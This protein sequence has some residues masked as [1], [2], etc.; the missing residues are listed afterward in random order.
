VQAIGRGLELATG[1]AGARG[2]VRFAPTRAFAELAGGDFASLPVGRPQAHSSNT[3]VTLGERLFLKGYR[4]IRPGV[5][6]ELEVGRFLTEVAR[7]PN[8]VP[9]AGAIEYTAADGTPMTL[10]LLQGY[11]ANQGDGWNY[12]LAYLERFFEAQ[13]GAAEP[14]AADVHGTYLA[15]AH[16]LGTRTAELHRALSQRTGNPA[17]DPE[18]VAADDLAH[19]KQ[20]VREEAATTFELL[21]RRRSQFPTPARDEMLA[22]LEK[23]HKLL[24]RVDACPQPGR[25]AAR[26]CS[27]RTTSSSSTSKASRRGRSPSAGSSTRRCATWPGCCARSTTRSGPRCAT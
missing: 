11:V 9:V 25:G 20:R 12:T 22:L 17:F 8:C 3:V 10:A 7:F 26:C 24:A 14:P 4:R 15:L 2:T 16:T 1:Q 27:T 21:E 13:R 23:R 5:N 18:P 19:W 6:P